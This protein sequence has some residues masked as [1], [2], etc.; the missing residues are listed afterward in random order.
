MKIKYIIDEIFQD[1]K[2]PS[3]LI[4]TY[5]CS[6]KCENCQNRHL[7]DEATTIDYPIEKIIDRYVNNSISESIVIGGLEPLEQQEDILELVRE[8]RKKTLDDI[9]IYT[10]FDK[11]EVEDFINELKKSHNIRVKFGRYIDDSEERFDEILGVT[12]ASSNQYAEII[13]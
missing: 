7:S 2:K 9:V 12:L 8:F 3:M 13:S 1:Y 11:N 4:A 10:G 6:F 5:K